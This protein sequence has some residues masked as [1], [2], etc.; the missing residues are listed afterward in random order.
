[1]KP[2]RLIFVLLLFVVV[3][4]WLLLTRT[5]FFSSNRQPALPT[6][7]P[8]GT[9]PSVPTDQTKVIQ[10]ASPKPGDP[11]YVSARK[12]A[13]TGKRRNSGVEDQDYEIKR[14]ILPRQQQP[15]LFSPSEEEDILKV[16]LASFHTLRTKQQQAR[17][18]IV[19]SAEHTEILLPAFATAEENPGDELFAS[20]SRVIGEGRAKQYLKEVNPQLRKLFLGFGMIDVTMRY[21]FQSDGRENLTVTCG[22]SEFSFGGSDIP[23][24]YVDL[25]QLE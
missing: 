24:E 21:E 9:E 1:M 22:A 20:L 7:K 19:H 17:K 5:T 18:L 15:P 4:L 6:S 10:I 11:T 12:A 25:I 13:R 16:M 14:M 3:L 2:S 23:I 8:I